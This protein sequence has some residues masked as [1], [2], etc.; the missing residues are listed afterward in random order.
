MEINHGHLFPGLQPMIARH[1]S[2]VLI[3]FA[4]TI[5]PRVKLA[6]TQTDPATS[7]RARISVRSD[8]C[9]MK[10]MIAS[11]TS[12]AT[13]RAVRSPQV[14]FLNAC[15]PLTAQRVPRFCAGVFAPAL[16]AFSD[17]HQKLGSGTACFQKRLF[18]SRKIVSATGKIPSGGCGASRTDLKQLC[19]RPDAR[20]ESLPSAQG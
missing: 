14:L 12:C 13:Q 8:Q 17:I 2:V 4:V 5:T 10:S 11:R 6:P 1:Q 16:Q 18:R 9:A 7:C 19:L 3:G 20:E 15:A